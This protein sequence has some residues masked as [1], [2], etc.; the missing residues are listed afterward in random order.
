[1]IGGAGWLVNVGYA[2]GLALIARYL[3]GVEVEVTAPM[4]IGPALSG[5][6]CGL[7]GGSAWRRLAERLAR[8]ASNAHMQGS[9]AVWVGF[10][11]FSV[12]AFS[13]AFVCVA[14]RYGQPA[15]QLTR[16]APRRRPPTARA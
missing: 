8:G 12:I 14:V 7:L 6:V 1:M 9:R 15:R 13:V 16:G 5:I 10:A 3:R 11:G 4:V 2:G